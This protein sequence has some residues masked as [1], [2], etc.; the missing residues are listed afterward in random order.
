MPAA[1]FLE[2][3]TMRLVPGMQRRLPERTV[4]R[5]PRLA[6][7]G[8]D[9]HRHEG[10]AGTDGAALRDAAAGK[11]G[12]DREAV[13]IGG[14]ALVGC[15]AERGVALQMLDRDVILSR[16]ERDVRG[17][18]VVL[19]IDE[20]LLQSA[21]HRPARFDGEG[22]AGRGAGCSRGGWR[23]KAGRG[24]GTMARRVRG[25]QRGPRDPACP[26]RPRPCTAAAQR[27][28]G[29]TTRG[30]RHRR[31]C[32]RTGRTDSPADRSRRRR[33]EDRRRCGG[34]LRRAASR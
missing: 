4:E 8:A 24:G 11:A 20:G 15:H 13:D 3:R 30:R 34:P 26:P 10:K 28:R 17:R 2:H 25:A 6:G 18:N 1:I 29:E 9:R 23:R 19:E 7:E 12:H 22:P 14:L 32:R 5:A 16:G 31:V 27:R 33:R 21:V